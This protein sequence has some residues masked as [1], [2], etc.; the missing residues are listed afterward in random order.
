MIKI[1]L[2]CYNIYCYVLYYKL[3]ITKI[4][5]NIKI[6]AFLNELNNLFIYLKLLL[7]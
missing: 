2:A 5:N 6:Y 3:F 7:K 1:S 4:I